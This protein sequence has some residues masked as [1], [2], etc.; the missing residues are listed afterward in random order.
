[1]PGFK[2]VHSSHIPGRAIC[3][4]IGQCHVWSAGRGGRVSPADPSNDG[5]HSAND[6]PL[7]GAAQPVRDCMRAEPW[8]HH[9]QAGARAGCPAQG[10]ALKTSLPAGKTRPEAELGVGA[11]QPDYHMWS[12]RGRLETTQRRWSVDVVVGALWP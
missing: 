2:D 12:V 3:T 9:E 1:M 10:G 8:E 4:K 6:D 5:R 7:P 11:S